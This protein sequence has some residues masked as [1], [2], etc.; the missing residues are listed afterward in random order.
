MATV[1][2][3][4]DEIRRQMATIRRAMHEDVKEVVATAEAATD[5]KRYLTAYPWV[6]LGAAFVVG[7]M[8]VPKRHK[9]AEALA[10]TQADL[11]KVREMVETTGKQVVASA[12]AQ[13]EPAPRRKGLIVAALGMVAPL[14]IR[15]AQGYAMKYLEQWILQQQNAALQ[16]GPA[17]VHPG[18]SSGSGAQQGGTGPGWP[19]NGPRRG[20]GPGS[21]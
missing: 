19:P 12:K 6:S 20:S 1:S 15:T 8:I 17:H 21:A 7:Y 2:N 4:V 11:S 13:V 16:A 5:W 10:A 9:T 18:F 14:V 3:D